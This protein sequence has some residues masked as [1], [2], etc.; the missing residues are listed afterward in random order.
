MK[1]R[2][3]EIIE[4]G[5]RDDTASK[6][7]DYVIVAAIITN[8]IAMLLSTFDQLHNLY[9]ALTFVDKSTG[10]LFVV[11]Y[12]LR[13]WTARYKYPYHALPAV[14]F[15]FS[16]SGVVD[17]LTILPIFV[18]GLLPGGVIAFRLIRVVR[19]FRLFQITANSDAFTVI[20]AVLKQRA[21]Q[22]VA[23][24]FFFG[25]LDVF[26]SL[27]MYYLEHDA[28]P[29]VFSNAFSGIWWSISTLLTVGYGDIYPVTT[30]GRV[31][32]IFVALLGVAVVAV[33]T[34]IV[35]AGFVEQYRLQAHSDRDESGLIK[36]TRNALNKNQRFAK[37]L[38][39]LLDYVEED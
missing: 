3:Y 13:L 17:L 28:Q 8:L 31:V 20:V 2:I 26:A 27:A 35:S 24:M 5:N 9:P 18:G 14:R 4:I 16:I 11:E 38:T 22:L 23:S 29:E 32:A 39:E 12:A 6:I 25:V 30:A 21:N 33:P 36:R 7:F 37:L 34:G 19:T 10:V 1:K 15:V